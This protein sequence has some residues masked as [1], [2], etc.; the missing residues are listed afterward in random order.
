MKALALK[1]S[2]IVL[3]RHDARAERRRVIQQIDLEEFL[4]LSREMRESAERWREKRNY[5]KKLM[6]AGA[7]I[8]PGVHTARLERR[9][10][11]H[12]LIPT[13]YR[14]LRVS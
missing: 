2:L 11:T 10:R 5:L 7:T 12:V 8:E 6:E 4:L 1:K 9:C 3:K 13:E 14:L